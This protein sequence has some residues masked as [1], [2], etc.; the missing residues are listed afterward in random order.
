MEACN[1]ERK[2]VGF[3]KEG[4]LSISLKLV[5]SQFQPCLLALTAWRAPLQP[6]SISKNWDQESN[7]K[8]WLQFPCCLYHQ[9]TFP[10]LLFHF[11]YERQTLLS[12][13]EETEAS[14]FSHKNCIVHIFM[15]MWNQKKC[16]FAYTYFPIFKFCGLNQGSQAHQ[17]GYPRPQSDPCLKKIRTK[18]GKRS[19]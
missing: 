3:K 5:R 8:Y 7:L 13:V 15:C 14:Y 18:G 17:V 1:S 19:F 9:L 11:F 16:M 12:Q 4:M 10:T 6:E 2:T